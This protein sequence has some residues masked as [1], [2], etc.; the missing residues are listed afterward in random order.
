MNSIVDFLTGPD[1]IWNVLLRFLITLFV[2]TVFIHGV[3]LRN[4]KSD[5]HA[6]SFFQMGVII[7]FVCILLKT[8]EIQMGMALGLFAIFALLRFRTENL[9]MK[10]M[11]YFFT[12][13]G[14]SVINAMAEFPSPVRGTI[15]INS[16][17][18]LTS[19]LLEIYSRKYALSKTLITYDQLELL[20]SGKK[21][22]LL[23]DLSLRTGW[24]VVR[25]EIK[26]IDSKKESAEIILYYKE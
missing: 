24:Q 22:E 1:P 2:L 17:I 7:F 14:I 19:Y 8:V 4:A 20:Q 3:Y 13:I 10:T 26:K 16:I 11:S 6:F 25:I 5:E 21:Q 12:V 9:P 18:I 23:K 15:L